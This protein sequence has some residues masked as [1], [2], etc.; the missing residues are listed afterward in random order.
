M[1]SAIYKSGL[2]IG[3]GEKSAGTTGRQWVGCLEGL[4]VWWTSVN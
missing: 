4:N 2:E 3:L 1:D